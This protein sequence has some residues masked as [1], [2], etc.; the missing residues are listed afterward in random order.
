[1]S[2]LKVG[3]VFYCF[4]PMKANVE[5]LASILPITYPGM[6]FDKRGPLGR[7]GGNARPPD[8]KR[9]LTTAFALQFARRSQLPIT[10]NIIIMNLHYVLANRCTRLF[11]ILAE[12]LAPLLRPFSHAFAVCPLLCLMLSPFQSLLS[13]DL[14]V[15]FS[16]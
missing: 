11:C 9:V 14:V 8:Q 4:S 16:R 3:S 5:I 6:W 1:M 2:L 15:W 10:Y 12:G 13:N 7:L